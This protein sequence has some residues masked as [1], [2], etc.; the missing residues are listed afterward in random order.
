MRG[1]RCLVL[2][3]LVSIAG[4]AGLVGG[5]QVVEDECVEVYR[6]VIDCE[7]VVENPSAD[8]MM[9]EVTVEVGGSG[10]RIF[11]SRSKTV[12]IDPGE[13]EEVSIAIAGVSGDLRYGVDVET[14][15]G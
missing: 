5:P 6:G 13:Q 12:E 10:D 14:V 9:V 11:E 8:P 3:A 1:T 4:C 15:D 7:V 2:V